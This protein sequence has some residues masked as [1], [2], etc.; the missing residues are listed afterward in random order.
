MHPQQHPWSGNE[1]CSYQLHRYRVLPTLRTS[2]DH[3][4]ALKHCDPYCSRCKPNCH[5]RSKIPQS[6]NAPM[7]RNSTAPHV[8][9]KGFNRTDQPCRHRQQTIGPNPHLFRSRYN[10]LL[11][12]QHLLEAQE[13]LANAHTPTVV[14]NKRAETTR[15]HAD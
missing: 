15:Q 14:G 13:V 1:L 11:T 12:V 6:M 2:S 10:L 9:R 3:H 7:Y 4:G 8:S 5:G